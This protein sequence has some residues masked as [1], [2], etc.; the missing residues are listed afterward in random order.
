MLMQSVLTRWFDLTLEIKRTSWGTGQDILTRH[1][2][3]QFQ[4]TWITNK[5]QRWFRSI[6][7]HSWVRISLDAIEFDSRAPIRLE[8][9][10]TMHIHDKLLFQYHLFA[11]SRFSASRSPCSELQYLNSIW[12][13]ILFIRCKIPCQSCLKRCLQLVVH[14]RLDLRKVLSLC[15]RIFQHRNGIGKQLTK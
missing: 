11:P 1:G 4:F 13:C 8:T 14:F 15:T 9:A 3:F 7:I 6:H 5:A 12:C 10:S 2:L